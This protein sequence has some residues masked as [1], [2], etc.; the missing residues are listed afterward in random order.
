MTTIL[1]LNGADWQCKPYLGLDWQMRGAH[2]ATTRDGY[3]WIP[4]TVPGSVQHDL[5]QAGEIANPYVGRNSLS[6]EW[7]SQRTWVYRKTFV[8]D[9]AYCGQRAYL[10]FAGVDYDAEFFLN[11]ESLGRH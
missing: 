1:S 5:W 9:E 3:G 4:A 11:G 2:K 6:A 10:R 8:V 7:A